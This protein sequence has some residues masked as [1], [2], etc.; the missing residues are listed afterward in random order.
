MHALIACQVAFCF[1][2]LFVAGLFTATFQR[3]SQLPLGFSAERVLTLE[4]I[5]EQERPA[6]YWDQ[7]AD[8]LRTVAGVEK[9]AICGWPL[10]NGNGWNGFVSINGGPPSGDLVYFLSISP[11][12]MDT[13]KIGFV[14]GRD[15][16]PN[17]TSPGAA[18]V[19]ET[20]VRM[21]FK[22]QNPIGRT[23]EKTFPHL[24]Y[25]IA[26]VVR[27]SPYRNVHEA[28]LPVAYVP[29]HQVSENGKAEAVRSAT[30]MVRTSGNPLAAAAVLRREVP[31]ARTDFRVSNIRSQ[32]EIDDAQTVRERLLA[33]LAM[34]FGLVALL[35]AGIGLFGVLD[36]TVVQRRR[37][38][39]IRMAL[40]ARAS[41]VA[42]GVTIE[43]FAMVLIGAGA[44]LGLGL[45]SARY[46]ASL[47]FEVKATDATMLALPM[48]TIL[49]AA[50]L[51]ALPA[52]VRAV[53]IDPAVT[54]R[55]E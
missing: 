25:E 33:M 26:G 21:F 13:M 46:I 54:L 38:I 52:V 50:L 18:I 8:H 28:I 48:V 43:V 51:A 22:D 2:V 55:A 42:R 30:F 20:F 15:F 47:L 29:F 34:F 32:Q 27:D 36:Y 17:E 4:T 37:E 53:R 24:R 16:R 35:L 40:G 19:N 44:G 3:L 5:A 12:W 39:G 41:H 14:A 23:F 10:L 11:G 9:V 49:G 7:V 45:T 6:V 1:V 31:R